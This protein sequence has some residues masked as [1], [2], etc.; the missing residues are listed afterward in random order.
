MISK[1]IKSL[2]KCTKLSKWSFWLGVI[3]WTFKLSW[4]NFWRISKNKLSFSFHKEN[5][6]A[7]RS[8]P[9]SV[10]LRNLMLSKLSCWQKISFAFVLRIWRNILLW[11]YIKESF[12]KQDW[13]FVWAGI[14]MLII[15]REKCEKR[16]VQLFNTKKKL[17]PSQWAPVVTVNW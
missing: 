7:Q 12:N 13:S 10:T 2:S 14:G 8:F 5:K 17:I 16:R 15:P 4:K 11:K 3:W 9:R 6:T 1:A